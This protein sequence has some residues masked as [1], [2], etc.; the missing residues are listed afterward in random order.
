MKRAV[1]IVALFS[2]LFLA[3]CDL[4]VLSPSGD[5]AQQQSDLIIYATVLMLIVILPVMAL[6]VFFAIKYRES[7]KKASYEPEW[8][9]SFS[10][11]IVI[12]SVP[13]AIIICLAGLTWVA[14]HRLDPYQPLT[15]ISPDQPV[16]PEVMPLVIQVASMDWKWLFIYPEQGIATVNEVAAIVD[17]PI[18]FQITS[19]TVMNS[20]YIPALAGQIYAMAG[21]QTEMNAVIN[22]PG[23][24]DGFS[25]NYSGAGFSQMRF[26]FHGMDPAGFDDWVAKVGTSAQ[27]LDADMLAKLNQ[28]SIA[29]PV[30]YYG[31]ISDTVWDRLVNTCIDADSLCRN[32]MMMVDAL[33]GGGLEGL[34]NREMF[35]GICS[36]EDPGAFI[37][38]LRPEMR[39]R[40]DEIVT[41][42]SLL[43]G[44]TPDTRH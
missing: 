7:N 38:M 4:V 34:W 29:D 1:H 28:P 12:W 8:H 40:G 3:G 13:L 18:E 23:V 2:C 32:D 5:V 21:M 10:L 16:N 27:V 41:A 36:A 15:R 44:I 39:L 17:R 24:Y 9:H 33:G 20:F 22:K 31:A 42:M 19:A 43:P 11:E 37:A 14:T 30:S 6:T 26:K 25:A 35:R